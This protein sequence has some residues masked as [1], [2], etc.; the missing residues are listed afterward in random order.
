MGDAEADAEED[1]DTSTLDM[2]GVGVGFSWATGIAEVTEKRAV[3]PMNRV[4]GCIAAF[5][6]GI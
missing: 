6:S 4:L 2:E 1:G 3:R 5:A